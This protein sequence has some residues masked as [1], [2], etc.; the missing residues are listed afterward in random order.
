[1][2]KMITVVRSRMRITMMMMMMTSLLPSLLTVH[3]LVRRRCVNCSVMLTRTAP[4]I[5]TAS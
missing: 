1:M 2:T 4:V 3:W 5:A